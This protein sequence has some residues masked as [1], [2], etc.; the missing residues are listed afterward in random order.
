M[1]FLQPPARILLES[2]GDRDLAMDENK[3]KRLAWFPEDLA[4]PLVK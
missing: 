4:N 1:V 2:H 3:G